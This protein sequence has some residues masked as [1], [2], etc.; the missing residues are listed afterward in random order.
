MMDIT[1][2]IDQ[3][4]LPSGEFTNES[5]LA[6]LIED[7]DDNCLTMEDEYMVFKS[8]GNEICVTFKTNVDGYLIRECGDWD[9]APYTHSEIRGIDVDIT[10]ITINECPVEISFDI[11]K[12]FESLVKQNLKK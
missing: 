6:K 3:L 9:T 5:A 1:I 12:V 10:E 4:N 11:S 7:E 8:N 2:D